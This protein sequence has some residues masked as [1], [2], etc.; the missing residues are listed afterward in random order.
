MGSLRILLVVMW[1][2]FF[3]YMV[4]VIVNYGWGFLEIFFGDMMIM[5]WL[6]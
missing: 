1:L 4:I 5:G 2:I 6:G 3:V